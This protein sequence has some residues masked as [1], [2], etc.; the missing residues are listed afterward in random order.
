M[1]RRSVALLKRRS[2]SGVELE[3]VGLL[4]NGAFESLLN[5]ERT[6]FRQSAGSTRREG[7]SAGVG[8]TL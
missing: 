1:I 2:E 5:R 4:K 8:L 6:L 3:F 7:H